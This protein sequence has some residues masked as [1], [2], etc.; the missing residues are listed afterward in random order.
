MDM[1]RATVEA[2]GVDVVG[3]V[4]SWASE[5]IPDAELMLEGFDMY[6]K[7]RDTGNRG[8]GV[9]LYVKTNLR[10][11]EWQPRSDYPEHVWCKVKDR[12][13]RDIKIGVIYRTCN[14]RIYGGSLHEKLMQL[15]TELREGSVLV[16][17]DFNYAGIDWDCH[18]VDSGASADCEEFLDCLDKC[19]LTQHVTEPTREGR[20]LDLVI[21]TDHDSVS[22][23]QVVDKLEKSDHNMIQWCYHL[24]AERDDGENSKCFDYKRADYDSMRMEL[25]E[26]KW[27]E[28]L[29][30]DV[31]EDWML[32]REKLL[33]IEKKYVPIRTF[34][35]KKK[36]SG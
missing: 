35:K 23:V 6:R 19:F 18:G 7:D 26:I 20:T 3:V 31:N 33:A 30:G 29:R 28:V 12:T 15:V 22:D 24:D 2:T 16:M 36:I 1:L 25:G 8:G 21:T 10:S 17:G 11:T 32:F 4:E 27:E 5:N 14:V 34:R 9:L 13:N